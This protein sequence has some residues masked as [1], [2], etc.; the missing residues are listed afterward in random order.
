MVCRSAR[1][2]QPAQRSTT[3]QRS[4]H[5]NS[6]SGPGAKT[7]H[8]VRPPLSIDPAPRGGHVKV[9][10]LTSRTTW[11]CP[12]T[13]LPITAVAGGSRAQPMNTAGEHDLGR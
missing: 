13:V 1:V 2:L 5:D 10:L 9:E 3:P 7:P 8:L 4:L 6:T 11:T 12:S